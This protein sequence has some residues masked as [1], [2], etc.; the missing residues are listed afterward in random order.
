MAPV[1]T[2]QASRLLGRGAR[3]EELCFEV[4]S[5]SGSLCGLRWAT[6]LKWERPG[7]IPSPAFL[8]PGF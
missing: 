3:E 6:A 5:T 1:H 8:A 7:Q 4:A 2:G